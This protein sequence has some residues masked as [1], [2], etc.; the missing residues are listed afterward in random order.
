MEH[1]SGLLLFYLQSLIRA[2][3]LGAIKGPPLLNIL[4]DAKLLPV[5]DNFGLRASLVCYTTN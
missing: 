5:F 2:N 1:L 4:L 3:S